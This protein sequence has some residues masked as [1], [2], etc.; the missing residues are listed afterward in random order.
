M[1]ASLGLEWIP[2]T[3]F[4]KESK[5]FHCEARGRM[6]REGDFSNLKY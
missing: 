6:L 4:K 1:A 5:D 3:D 2:T